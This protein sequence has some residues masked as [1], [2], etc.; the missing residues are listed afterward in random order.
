MF[1]L[2]R[3]H[4]RFESDHLPAWYLVY[5]RDRLETRVSPWQHLN[6]RHIVPYLMYITVVK[7]EYHYSN[8]FG[9]LF[10]AV[11]CKAFGVFNFLSKTWISLERK[12]PFFIILKGQVPWPFD[13]STLCSTDIKI[14]RYNS[15]K[16]QYLQ[17]KNGRYSS[18]HLQKTN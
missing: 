11:I 17:T 2:G 10:V 1:T 5:C 14:E 16:T 6:G 13:S 9:D 15:V 18:T 4:T 3:Q 8:I 12:T 7:F